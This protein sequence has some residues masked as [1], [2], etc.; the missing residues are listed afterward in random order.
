MYAVV[1]QE[2]LEKTIASNVKVEEAESVHIDFSEELSKEV[3]QFIGEE[4]NC[5]KE[6]TIEKLYGVLGKDWFGSSEQL[7]IKSHEPTPDGF[8]FEVKYS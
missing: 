4:N 6:V 5:V 3:A 7:S 2:E 1:S 8:A